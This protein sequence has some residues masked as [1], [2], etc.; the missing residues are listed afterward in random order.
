M[1]LSIE[2]NHTIRIIDAAEVSK[3]DQIL[4][5]LSQLKEQGKLMAD[6]NQEA[7]DLLKKIDDATTAQGTALA[8]EGTNLQTVSD[9]LD[10][11][12]ST[13]TA[14]GTPQ[15]V[16]DALQAQADKVTAIGANIQKQADFSLQL[17]SKGTSNPVPVPPP[18]PLPVV[19]P[20]VAPKG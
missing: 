13:A 11:L 6:K 18:P 4:T 16:L 15:N 5:L 14:A 19:P 8:T 2:I 3:L 12:I 7:L 20:I 17:A 10:K 1:T 9:N